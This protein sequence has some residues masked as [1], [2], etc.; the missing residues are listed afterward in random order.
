[1]VEANR[2]LQQAPTKA[3]L[4][5]MNAA[6]FTLAKREA[7]KAIERQMHAERLRLSQIPLKVIGEAAAEHLA[8]HRS[9][10]IADAKVI[11]ERWNAD[12]MFG[13][14]GGIRKPGHRSSIARAA[15]NSNAQRSEG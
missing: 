1:M 8:Q 5:A 9:E 10:L 6:V 3:Q 2:S 4:N 15:L 13:P 11:V 7:L 14:R 12:G